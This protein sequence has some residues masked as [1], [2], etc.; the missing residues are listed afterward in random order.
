MAGSAATERY[1]WGDAFL[2]HRSYAQWKDE[3]CAISHSTEL[4]SSTNTAKPHTSIISTIL[5]ESGKFG[6]QLT[7]AHQ[8]I[9]QLESRN[10]RRRAG[11]LLNHRFIQGR[12]RRCPDNRQ[13]ARLGCADADA[14]LLFQAASCNHQIPAKVYEYLRLQKPILALTPHEGD[15]AALLDEVGG[16]TVVDLADVAA[17]VSAIPEFINRVR[18]GRHPL[19]SSE[20]VRRYARSRQACDLAR[21]LNELTYNSR[22]T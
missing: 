15:T 10:P 5:A 14:L 3:L 8:F 16:A 17:L 2:L 19:C 6:L 7:L 12:G 18:S 20:A 13:G 11:Q 21:T 4:A 22:S 9:S 1:D